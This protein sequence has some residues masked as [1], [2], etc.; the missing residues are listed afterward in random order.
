[1]KFRPYALVLTGLMLVFLGIGGWLYYEAHQD[2]I[3]ASL[4]PK[5]TLTLVEHPSGKPMANTNILFSSHKAVVCVMSV[6]APCP[7]NAVQLKTHTDAKGHFTVPKSYIQD[8][9]EVALMPGPKTFTP[10]AHADYRGETNNPDDPARL[11]VP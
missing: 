6:G 8:N 10:I 2:G 7:N 9:M 11:I 4:E 5:V 3:K 1:M